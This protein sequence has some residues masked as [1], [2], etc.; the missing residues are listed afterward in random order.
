MPHLTVEYSANLNL[1]ADTLHN[2]NQTLIQSG[3]F[4]PLDIK[5]RAHRFD[6]FL[7]G[8]QTDGQAFVHA[9]LAI[10]QGRSSAI[11]AQLAAQLLNALEACMVNQ[12]NP[13]TQLC[14]EII[15]IDN[16]SYAKKLVGV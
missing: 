8:S 5:S 11:K 6:N 12:P 9:K 14:I 2:L 15:E 3:H 13:A 10:M 7:I 16:A 1:P 4:E